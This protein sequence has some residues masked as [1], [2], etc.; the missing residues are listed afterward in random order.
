MCGLSGS[1]LAVLTL[2]TQIDVVSSKSEEFS[3]TLRNSS[4]LMESIAARACVD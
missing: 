4:E 1:P 3:R 2:A